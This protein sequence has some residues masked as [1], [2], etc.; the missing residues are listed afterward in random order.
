MCLIRGKHNWRTHTVSVI[1][2]A[3][4]SLSLCV[5]MF[6]AV[7]CTWPW[8][9]WLQLQT[10]QTLPPR[11]NCLY[12]RNAQKLTLINSNSLLVQYQNIIF[13]FCPG[14]VYLFPLAP[15]IFAPRFFHKPSLL[16]PY[17]SW[18]ILPNFLFFL[19]SS[20]QPRMAFH[21]LAWI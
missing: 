17:A 8:K 1:H 12:P 6:P 10:I 7:D 21:V 15:H 13:S 20:N 11:H 3:C 4:M 5:C 19:F 18:C 9:S 16:V 2:I 14:P